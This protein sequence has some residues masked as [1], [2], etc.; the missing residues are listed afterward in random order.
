[1]KVH[2]FWHE[3]YEPPVCI[4]SWVVLDGSVRVALVSREILAMDGYVLR[5]A[6]HAE[7]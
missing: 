2:L 6:C 1:M 5:C 3:S 7:K 4:V